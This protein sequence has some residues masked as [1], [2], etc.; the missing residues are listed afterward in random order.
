MLALVGE[1]DEATPPVMSR[2]IVALLPAAE[3]MVL[4]GCAHV[5]QL[6]APDQFLAAVM[7]FLGVPESKAAGS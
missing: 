4:P 5:P 3:L 1:Q 7:P 2:E 6:Q